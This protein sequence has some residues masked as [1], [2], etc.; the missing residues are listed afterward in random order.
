MNAPADRCPLCGGHRKAGTTT[1]SVDLTFG[2]VVVRDVPA[3]V[4]TQCGDAWIDDAIAA[5]LES[6]VADARTR[7]TVVEVVQW[8]AIAA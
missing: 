1:F 3:L 4:C 5:R 6:L 7:Q 8:A 2:V